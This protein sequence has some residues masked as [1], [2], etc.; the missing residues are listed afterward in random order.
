M[1][2]EPNPTPRPAFTSGE[3][4][5]DWIN[6]RIGE[7]VTRLRESQGMTPYALGLK[8]GVSDQT[9]LNIEHGICKRGYLTGTLAQIAFFFGITLNELID[10]AVAEEQR[11]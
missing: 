11:Q 1:P 7:E 6:R 5:A 2:N 3:A 4:Y 10:A 9:I 8:C